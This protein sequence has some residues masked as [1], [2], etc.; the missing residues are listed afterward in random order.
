MQHQDSPVVFD[1]SNAAS[2]DDK[3]AAMAPLRDALHLLTRA[4]LAPLPY[5]ARV[6]CVGAGTGA[7]ILY[8]AQAFPKWSFTAVEP[9]AAMLEI[10]RRRAEE[11]G[12]AARCEFHE[13]L[14]DSLPA[15]PPF[16]AA[17][18]L[19]VSHFIA[20]PEARCEFFRQIAAH[21][22]PGAALVNA[23]LASDM[24]GASYRNLLEVWRTTLGFC[25]IPADEIE[26]MTGSFGS[27][28]ALF[29]LPET[30]AIIAASGFTTPVPFLQTLLIHGWFA[31]R[32]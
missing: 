10:C 14:L 15:A 23:E 5:N 26:K 20:Q 16:D 12:I 11:N 4:I 1:K 19:L 32:L 22:L 28:V 2:Y 7:E 18:S 6:L 9:A 8:L 13:G 25:A 30:A 21:L 31:R 3:F 17:T 29:P 24:S 27:S